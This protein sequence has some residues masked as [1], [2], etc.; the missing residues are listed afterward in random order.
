MVCDFYP[1]TVTRNSTNLGLP[2]SIP[3]IVLIVWVAS[4]ISDEIF[5]VSLKLN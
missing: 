4:F 1:L 2:I 5:E 3:E